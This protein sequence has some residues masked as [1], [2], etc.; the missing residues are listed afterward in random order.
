MIQSFRDKR[1][2]RIFER[3]WVKGISRN[4]QRMILR[5]LIMIDAAESI[6]AL[7]VPPANRLEKLK[8]DRKG[9]YSIR[10]NDRLRICFR[11]KEQYAFD[12]EIADYH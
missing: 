3:R 1:T 4:D 9:Q 5:K 10:V 8:G 6:N 12:V 7:R 2:E 11:W